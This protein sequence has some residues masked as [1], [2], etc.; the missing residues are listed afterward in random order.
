LADSALGLEDIA[1]SESTIGY[2]MYKAFLRAEPTVKKGE[3]RDC[4]SFVQ[5]G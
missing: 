5:G 1:L 2:V 3:E 4:K